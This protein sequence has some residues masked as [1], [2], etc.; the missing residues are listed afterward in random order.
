M[1]WVIV[2]LI[3][4]TTFSCFYF[5]KVV[6]LPYLVYQAGGEGEKWSVRC[7]SLNR[8]FRPLFWSYN[9]HLQVIVHYIMCRKKRK[10]FF[11]RNTIV[12][13][14]AGTIALDWWDDPEVPLPASA[15]VAMVLYT[16]CGKRRDFAPFAQELS[17]KG[18]RVVVLQRRGHDGLELTAP[19]LNPFGCTD[20]LKVQVD[21]IRHL[22]PA[23]PLFMYGE[24]AGTALLVKYLGEQGDGAPIKAA[25]ACCPGYDLERA[26]T[27]VTSFYDRLMTKRMIR[28]FLYRHESMLKAAQGYDE[29]EASVSMKDFFGNIYKIAGFPNSSSFFHELNPMHVARKITVPLLVLNAYDDPVCVDR[30]ARDYEEIFRM[31][32]NLLM[33]KTK[34]GSHCAFYEG[35]FRPKSW[36]VKM[37]AEFFEVFSSDHKK[38]YSFQGDA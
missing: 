38:S 27:R 13:R 1:E 34:R 36:S 30:N 11:R 32:P 25:I 22:Y 17:R 24:S 35:W 29:C 19:K 18:L 20:D 7:P 14:D 10:D 2:G 31:A 4:F 37:T 3:A 12:L 8:P 16:I 5:L 21:H 6:D 33:V 15:P 9:R 28:F 23:A 26:F